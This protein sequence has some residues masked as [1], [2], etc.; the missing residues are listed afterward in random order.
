M[1][2]SRGMTPYSTELLMN[3]NRLFVLGDRRRL[4]NLSTRPLFQLKLPVTLLLVSSLFLAVFVAHTHAAYGKLIAAGFEHAFLANLASEIR[5]D[6]LVVSATLAIAWALAI[7]G[8]CLTLTHHF[9][10]PIVALRRQIEQLKRGEYSASAHI[11]AGHPLRAVADELDGLARFLSGEDLAL[12]KEAEVLPPVFVT[13]SGDAAVLES[14]I[15]PELA[16][17]PAAAAANA[18]TPWIGW[19]ARSAQP[20]S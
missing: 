1:T 5:F 11:R 9:L 6:Y 16:L 3:P 14:K 18:A 12:L 8:V 7:V 17:E 20:S 2:Q 10:G 4:V 19:Y 15:E 13:E